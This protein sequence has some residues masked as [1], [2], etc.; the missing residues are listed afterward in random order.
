MNWVVA[1]SLR[2]LG[3]IPLKLLGLL[4]HRDWQEED[5]W[6]CSELVAW[7][8]TQGGSPLFRREAMHRIT[9]QHLWMLAPEPSP[10][11]LEFFPQLEGRLERPS[12]FQEP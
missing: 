1:A 10:P 4:M 9:P 2:M 6:F 5:R 11:D 8:F 7:A 12:S 3:Q